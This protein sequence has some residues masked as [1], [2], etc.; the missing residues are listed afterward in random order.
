MMMRVV[1]VMMMMV[2]MVVMTKWNIWPGPRAPPVRSRPRRKITARSYSWDQRHFHCNHKWQYP[3]SS[4]YNFGL[5]AK[6]SY[7]NNKFSA[8]GGILSQRGEGWFCCNVAGVPQ[9]QPKHHQKSHQKSPITKKKWDFSWKN[10][11]LREAVIREKKDFLWKSLFI[12][13]S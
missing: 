3:H 2:M 4:H 1:V 7:Q 9:S 10:T 12:Y 6:G 13:F 11:M 5:K 8:K